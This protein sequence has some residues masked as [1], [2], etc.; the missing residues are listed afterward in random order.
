MLAQNGLPKRLGWE[1]AESSWMHQL[2]TICL[3]KETVFEKMKL[4]LLYIEES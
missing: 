4:K 1:S 3:L 2:V